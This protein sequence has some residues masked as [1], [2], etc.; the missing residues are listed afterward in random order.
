MDAGGGGEGGDE[1]L[2]GV[3][4]AVAVGNGRTEPSINSLLSLEQAILGSIERCE[5]NN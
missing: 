2:V 4:E 1:D 5:C 3:E